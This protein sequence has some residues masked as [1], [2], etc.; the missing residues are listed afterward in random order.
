MAKVKNI[1][2]S[3]LHIR[4][5]NYIQSADFRIYSNTSISDGYTGALRC[6][7]RYNEIDSSFMT[8]SETGG[9]GGASRWTFN[10]SCYVLLTVSQDVDGNTD[11]GYWWMGPKINGSFIGNHLVRKTT[12]WDML[13]FQQSFSVTA[14]QYLEIAWGST[15]GLTNVDGTSWSHYGFLV[16]QRY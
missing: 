8:F 15:S 11:N 6:V 2:E 1:V 10:K 16:W 3:S 9:T 7:A 5:Y 4:G 14:T 12:E 13:T